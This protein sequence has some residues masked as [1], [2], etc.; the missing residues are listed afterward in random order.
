MVAEIF[1]IAMS[2]PQRCHAHRANSGLSRQLID[3]RLD[4]AR[5]TGTRHI[6]AETMTT[7]KRNALPVDCA[8]RNAASRGNI[9]RSTLRCPTASVL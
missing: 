9:M 7:H 3:E 8:A 6:G 1:A 5:C 4:V 2:L